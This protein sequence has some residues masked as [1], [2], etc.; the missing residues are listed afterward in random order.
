MATHSSILAQKIPWREEPGRLQSMGSQRVEH[1]WATK[2]QHYIEQTPEDQN[3]VLSNY[4]HT[5]T[6]WLA[7]EGICTLQA[8][9]SFAQFTF[10][11]LKNTNFSG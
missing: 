7:G 9:F 8:T 4:C 1:D 3:E 5:K 6:A 10:S 11:K 2:L